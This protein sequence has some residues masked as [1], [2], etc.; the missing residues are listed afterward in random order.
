M[1]NPPLQLG[2]ELSVLAATS[3]SSTYR[4]RASVYAGLTKVRLE[5]Q[6]LIDAEEGLFQ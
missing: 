1:Y 3:T 5:P 4:M 2:R 6:V